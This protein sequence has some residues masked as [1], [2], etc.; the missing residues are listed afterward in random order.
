[1]HSLRGSFF[2]RAYIGLISEQP[3]W[4]SFN[5]QPHCLGSLLLTRINF[6]LSMDKLSHA[7]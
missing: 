6:N 5:S 3:P 7:Q 1:M 4:E 2:D